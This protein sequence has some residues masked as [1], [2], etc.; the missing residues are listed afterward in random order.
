MRG[1]KCLV[2]ITMVGMKVK[3]ICGRC[4]LRLRRKMTKRNREKLEILVET[5]LNTKLRQ[6]L[7][8][9]LGEE[10]IL[11]S[12]FPRLPKKDLTSSDL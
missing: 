3:R 2:F 10:L 5:N 12:G 8:K 4:F 7:A 11:L 6:A 9:K 1:K